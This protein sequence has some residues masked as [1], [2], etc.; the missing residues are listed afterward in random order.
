MPIDVFRQ[1]IVW[2][3]GSANYVPSALIS[4]SLLF[5]FRNVLNDDAPIYPKWYNYVTCFLGVAGALF[6]ENI[7]IFNVMFA[8]I[9]IIYSKIKH[10]KVYSCQIMLLIGSIVGAVIMFT[11]NAYRTIL[12]GNDGYREVANSSSIVSRVSESLGY[13]ITSLFAENY[14]YWILISIILAISLVYYLKDNPNKKWLISQVV[15]LFIFMTLFIVCKYTS[16][17]NKY[18]VYIYRFG[19]CL[20]PCVVIVLLAYMIPK[21]KLLRLFYPLVCLL[22]MFVPLLVVSPIGPRNFFSMYLM[23]MV[24]AIELL[25]NLISQ[26][27]LAEKVEKIFGVGVIVLASWLSVV[28]FV[29]FGTVK[30]YDNAR[31]SFVKQQAED[32][33]QQIY[34]CALP[35]GNYIHNDLYNKSGFIGEYMKFNKISVNK[36]SEYVFF[37]YHELFDRIEE[38]NRGENK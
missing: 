27:D 20:I 31:M 15:L 16:L 37:D 38:Y 5:M 29:I 6:M 33:C 23:L 10:K 25:N 4:L 12:L 30:K 1:V 34:I 17:V 3:S 35:Y 19:F 28:M 7:T 13:L 2:K 14:V 26:Y 8:V 24:F 21:K 22:L 32:G 36:E 9:I 11:N 18:S